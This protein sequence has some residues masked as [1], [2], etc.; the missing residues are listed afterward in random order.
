[1]AR[2]GLSGKALAEV[3]GVSH[4]QLYMARERHVGPK[5]AAKIASGIAGKLG[6]SSEDE[7]A[8]KASLG[9]GRG[10]FFV[11]SEPRADRLETRIPYRPYL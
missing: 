6:L 10:R 2:I 9:L 8:L 11:G 3:V 7:L 1:M 4:S 5:N